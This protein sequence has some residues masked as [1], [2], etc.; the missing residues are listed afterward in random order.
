VHADK[1]VLLPFYYGFHVGLEVPADELYR[2]LKVVEKNVA[3]LAKSDPGFSQIRDD[4][5]G[6]QR[7]GVASSIDFVPVHPGLAKYMR[8]KGV[9][10]A[11]W[12]SRIA[13]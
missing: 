9:W 1:V 6:M 4:M 12:D 2:M 5:A 8:E 13:K 7:K 3:A 11:K 10:D